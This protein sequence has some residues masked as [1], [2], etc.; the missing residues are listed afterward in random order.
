MC[1]QAGTPN[2]MAPELVRESDYST[3]ADMWALGCVMYEMCA[4]KPA[5]T[6]F[7]MGGL[8]TKIQS[9]KAPLIPKEY[10]PEWRAL[11]RSLLHAD[12]AQRPSATQLL[13][14]PL[15]QVR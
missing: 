13:D 9:G 3:G 12:E 1:T 15:L 6:S 4:L 10:S 11:A 2:Y 14:H 5:F 7:T 8:I